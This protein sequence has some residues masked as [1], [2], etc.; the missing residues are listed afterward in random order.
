MKLI[1]LRLPGVIF[2]VVDDSTTTTMREY[3]EPMGLLTTLFSWVIY[4]GY[5]IKR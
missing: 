2:F 4:T 3:I 5:K 1:I